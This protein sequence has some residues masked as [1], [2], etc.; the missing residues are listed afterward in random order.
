MTEPGPD[1]KVW[2]CVEVES[3]NMSPCSMTY[4]Q[5]VAISR[6]ATVVWHERG[7]TNLHR[8]EPP[9]PV[10]VEE[11]LA[12]LARQRPACPDQCHHRRDESPAHTIIVQARKAGQL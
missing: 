2:G 6:S 12:E 11:A 7:T 5:A 8:W 4:A 9:E 3:G 10:T 1:E